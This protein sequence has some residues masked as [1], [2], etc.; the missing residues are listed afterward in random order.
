M[1]YNTLDAGPLFTCT[2]SR[3]CGLMSF[4][5]DGCCPPTPIEVEFEPFS[6]RMPS[7]INTGSLDSDTLLEPRM[8]TRVPVPVVP[9]LDCTTT[10]GT[11]ELSASERLLTAA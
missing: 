5:R 4:R 1:P 11:V 10:P 2:A 7:T 9:P 3:S 6:T 8:R